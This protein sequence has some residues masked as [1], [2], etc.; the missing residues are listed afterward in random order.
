MSATTKNMLKHLKTYLAQRGM[1]VVKYS[2]GKHSNMF[3]DTWH[4]A[5]IVTTNTYGL[6]VPGVFNGGA[7]TTP[8][9][10]WLAL[11]RYS[12]VRGQ[13]IYTVEL[14]DGGNVE[15]DENVH[16]DTLF[17]TFLIAFMVCRHNDAHEVRLSDL[18][19]GR[20]ELPELVE[21]VLEIGARR[22]GALV[23]RLPVFV[24]GPGRNRV[25][26]KTLTQWRNTLFPLNTSAIRGVQ[27]TTSGARAGT[28]SDNGKLYHASGPGC[29]GRNTSHANR[30]DAFLLAELLQS[31]AE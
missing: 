14:L 22:G 16:Y 6:V 18:N 13:P 3:D 23:N 4:D 19:I 8:T 20:S 12:K 7:G 29:R 1:S 2:P 17:R 15:L 26:N 9:M 30:F 31:M 25:I 21:F 10:E 11:A 24:R 27:C 5:N 28:R